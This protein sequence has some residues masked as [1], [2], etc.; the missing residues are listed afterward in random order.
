[1]M[2]HACNS[3]IQEAEVASL[4]G[5]F[6][7]KKKKPTPTTFNGIRVYSTVERLGGMH[8]V[9]VSDPHHWEIRHINTS[10]LP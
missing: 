10:N 4:L 8:N 6:L 5:H 9:N 3:S 1:M 7:K 2:V